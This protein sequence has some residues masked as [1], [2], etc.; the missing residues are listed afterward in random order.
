MKDLTFVRFEKFAETESLFLAREPETV[1]DFFFGAAKET[2]ELKNRRT[3]E[4]KTAMSR[5]NICKLYTPWYNRGNFWWWGNF[6][7]FSSGF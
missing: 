1:G 3:K 6:S 7:P 4:H 2:E 5:R